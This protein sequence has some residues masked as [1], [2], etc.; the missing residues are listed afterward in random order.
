MIFRVLLC[1]VAVQAA[2]AFAPQS[3]PVSGLPRLT[4]VSVGA[5]VAWDPAV[6]GIQEG[7]QRLNFFWSFE[8]T[9][10][11]LILPFFYRTKAPIRMDSASTPTTL[12]D[13]EKDYRYDHRYN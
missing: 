8:N 5:S 9:Y 6:E 13:R 11:I 2:S 4:T 7:K 12:S 3:K 10:S 1:L